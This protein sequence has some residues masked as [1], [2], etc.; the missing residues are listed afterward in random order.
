MLPEGFLS[1]QILIAL[2]VNVDE[3]CPSAKI[4]IPLVEVIGGSI[5][6]KD[7]RPVYLKPDTE[8]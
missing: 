6:A 5:I 1:K 4:R 8:E 7:I 2:K 3:A